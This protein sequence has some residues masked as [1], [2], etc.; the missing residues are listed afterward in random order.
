[1]ES[2]G[3]D[4]SW[5]EN[6]KAGKQKDPWIKLQENDSNDQCKQFQ[7]PAAAMGTK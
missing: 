3:I 7:L 2:K 5:W 1:M 4:I 6:I